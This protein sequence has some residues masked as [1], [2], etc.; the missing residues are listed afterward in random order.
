[1]EPTTTEEHTMTTESAIESLLNLFGF[2][3]FSRLNARRAGLEDAIRL[4]ESEGRARFVR[5]VGVSSGL[6][7]L[8]ENEIFRMIA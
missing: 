7:Y 6:P 2:A 3:P 1:M 8:C 4:A 5:C